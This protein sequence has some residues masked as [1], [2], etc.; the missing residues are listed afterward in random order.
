[1]YLLTRQGAY[2]SQGYLIPN[3]AFPESMAENKYLFALEIF[4]QDRTIFSTKIFVEI[5]EYV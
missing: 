4:M 1:M 3:D 5:K 2:Q